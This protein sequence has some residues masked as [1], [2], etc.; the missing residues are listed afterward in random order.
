MG[1]NVRIIATSSLSFFIAI[2]AIVVVT[3]E[4]F[5]PRLQVRKSSRDGIRATS[6]CKHYQR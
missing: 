6:R 3:M 4:G 2:S 5:K 1:L